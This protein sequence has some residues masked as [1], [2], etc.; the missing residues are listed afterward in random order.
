[1]TAAF[2]AFIQRLFADEA[3]IA[4]ANILQSNLR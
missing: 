1:V 4:E 3:T 2:T